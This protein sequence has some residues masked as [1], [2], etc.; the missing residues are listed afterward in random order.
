MELFFFVFILIVVIGFSVHASAQ[1]AK[2]KEDA[3]RQYQEY[4]GHYRRDPTNPTL[5]E[6]AL[7][8]GRS[9]S[10]LCRNSKGVTIY[11]EVAL[12]N[13]LNAAGAAA[14]RSQASA[15]RCPSQVTRLTIGYRGLCHAE[16]AT[17]P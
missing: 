4:L 8:A 9:Y 16:C 14:K 13:D 15:C 17:T 10:N 3:W 12:M 11:D 5:R 2:A 6:Y 1:R 7:Q